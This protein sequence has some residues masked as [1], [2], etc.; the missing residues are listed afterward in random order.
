MF[1]AGKFAVQ[2]AIYCFFLGDLKRHVA[3]HWN[4]QTRKTTKVWLIKY[5]PLQ[6]KVRSHE[7]KHEKSIDSVLHFGA[8]S[9]LCCSGVWRLLVQFVLF[10]CGENFEIHQFP[11]SISTRIVSKRV[12]WTTD[13]LMLFVAPRPERRTSTG[14]NLSRHVK[15]KFQ[16]WVVNNT[17]ILPARHHWMNN[18][19]CVFFWL[20]HTAGSGSTWTLLEQRWWWTG[21]PCWATEGRWS[22]WKRWKENTKGCP[23]TENS[24]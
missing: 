9:R 18:S 22:C 7:T 8:D 21:S 15:S 1:L 13:H 2:D 6:L 16:P 17:S 12:S 10:P 5:C 20:N 14:A 24:A 11:Y 4:F 3:T 23:N 19:L